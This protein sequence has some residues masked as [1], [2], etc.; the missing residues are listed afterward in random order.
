MVLHQFTPKS[1]YMFRGELQDPTIGELARVA[2]SMA[3]ILP[4]RIQRSGARGGVSFETDK[5]D[6]IR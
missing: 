6:K 1:I 4:H 3:K 2:A 5:S